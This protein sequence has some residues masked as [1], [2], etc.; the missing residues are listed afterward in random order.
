MREE[1]IK[2]M[3]NKNWHKK[4]AK[5]KPYTQSLFEHSLVV[6]DII[7]SIIKLLNDA[8]EKFSDKEKNILRISAILHDIGK[9]KAEWQEA[10]KKGQKP[11]SHIDEDL[12][13]TAIS[14]LKKHIKIE[15]EQTIL[16]CIGLHHKA[17]QSAGNI[18]NSIMSETESSNWKELQDFVDSVDNLASCGTLLGAIELLE[19]KK[20]FR[21]EKLFKHTYHK[22]YLR[23][24]SSIFLH[25]A[26]QEA[27]K[28]KGWEPILYFPEGTCYLSTTESKEIKKEEISNKL[29]QIIHENIKEN[30]KSLVVPNIIMDKKAIPM[31]ELFDYE[32]L[33]FYLI[34]VRGRKNPTDFQKYLN[35]YSKPELYEKFLENEICKKIIESYSYYYV[36][37]EN[38]DTVTK[39]KIKETFENDLA[40]IKNSLLSDKNSC[41]ESL[42]S[43][44]EDVISA[45]NE[46]ACFKFFQASIKQEI[47]GLDITEKIKENYEKIFGQRTFSKLKAMSNNDY[48]NEMAYSIYPFWELNTSELID[49]IGDDELIKT[50]SNF[51]KVA[52]LKPKIRKEVLCKILHYIWKKIEIEEEN[53]P[54]RKIESKMA[55]D[56]LLDIQYPIT[57]NNNYKL[58]LENYEKSKINSKKAS[59][60]HVCPVCNSAFNKGKLSTVDIVDNPEGFTNRAAAHGK[61]GK[62]VICERC[63][64]EI[65]LKKLLLNQNSFNKTIF[66]F[67]QYN[68]SSQIGVEFLKVIDDLRQKTENLMSEFSTNPEL[69]PDFSKTTKIALNVIRNI[70][71]IESKTI[72]DFILA[73]NRP[74]DFEKEFIRVLLEYN[75]DLP[76]KKDD[77]KALNII[78]NEFRKAYKKFAEF[79]TEIKKDD[80]FREMLSI[81]K[82]NIKRDEIDKA[83]IGYFGDDFPIKPNLEKSLEMLNNDFVTKYD[84]WAAFIDDVKRNKIKSDIAKD[85]VKEI[86]KLIPK[87]RII[88]QTPNFVII[89]LK[90]SLRWSDDSDINGCIRELFISIVFALKLN[91]SIAIADN[92]LK[93]DIEQRK[94]SVFVPENSLLQQLVGDSWLRDYDFNNEKGI[95]IKSDIKWLKAIASVLCLS[96]RTAYSDRTN[97][98]DILK[99]K[100][101]G[102]LL[103]RIEMK[104]EK[105]V[106]NSY[107]YDY[108]ENIWEV[109]E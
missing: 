57:D 38:S 74:K 95:N 69:I 78:N 75:P 19:S 30:A 90:Q 96:Y 91:C 25:K 84:N 49:Y 9:E 105:Q 46:V 109:K 21:I 88:A 2:F 45:Q 63:R 41:L 8:S 6:Y 103:R 28:A 33:P 97:L 47:W 14:D 39:S 36:W 107:V 32:E 108:I 23:G 10:V 102:H 106:N 65:Y 104:E 59:G 94:G 18:I 83:L 67:P 26:C 42:K 16:R 5:T 35:S 64:S 56:F 53:K 71:N 40:K 80:Q 44:S 79:T 22:I 3:R 77:S 76:L 51:T 72:E 66:L 61:P 11:P 52:Q 73:D 1:L 24:V 37:K 54:K 100:T 34:E 17:A 31:P 68:F 58:Q 60:D 101:K 4:I 98:Y 62:I 81:K 87:Y 13:K 48:S 50:I 89:P 20:N 92:I 93:I 85:I 43:Y 29:K 99:S 15:D 12:A 7:D 70:D 55:N 82:K 86:Y 27:Y